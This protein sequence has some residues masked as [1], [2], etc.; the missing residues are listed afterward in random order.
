MRTYSFGLIA[1]ICIASSNTV[2][3]QESPCQYNVPATGTGTI[4]SIQ[5]ALGWWIYLEERSDNGPCDI[6]EIS[7]SAV[8]DT[9]L[10]GGKVTA[11]GMA[12]DSGLSD[13]PTLDQVTS[14]QCE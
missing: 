2:K 5:N 4:R 7:V 9:C 1:I 10:V 3:A 6:R 14:L 12:V 13:D 8:P 11:A